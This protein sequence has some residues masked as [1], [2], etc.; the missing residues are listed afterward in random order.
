MTDDPEGTQVFGECLAAWEGLRTDQRRSI[1]LVTLPMDNVEE[2]AVLV[3]ALQRHATVVVQKSLQEGFGL[4]VTE[5]MWNSR[6]VIASAVG[7]IVDQIAPG[8]GILLKDPSDLAAFGDTLADL[9]D[10]PKT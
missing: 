1:R 10:R 2:N 8:T 6:P 5:A 9:L 7:G 3:N 4:T